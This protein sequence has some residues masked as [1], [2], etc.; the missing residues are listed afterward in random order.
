MTPDPTIR[1]Q[2][3]QYFLQEAPELLQALEEGLLSLRENWGINQVN[4]LMR[5]THTLKG[6]AT[7]MG[8]DTIAR[9]AHSLEDIFKAL[10]QPDLS[11]DPEVEALL[12]E[13]L[14]CLRLPLMAELTQGSINDAEVLN[15]T[16]AVFA[17]LQDKLGDCFGREPYLPTSSELGFDLPQSLFEVGVTQ[18]LEQIATSLTA[19]DPESVA[20]VL[21]TQAEVLLGLA[22]SL[23]LCGFGAIAQSAIAALDCHP[24]QAVLIA[25]TALADFQAGQAA[26]LAGDRAQGGEPSI[27]LQQFAVPV[28]SE[29]A[30]PIEDFS[31]LTARKYLGKF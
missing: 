8:L 15:R 10:C 5:A 12:F 1:A 30:L 2:T 16:A 14:E 29:A 27:G 4:N 25:Q 21:R 23:N 24:E 3:Y 7:S 28:L 22:E 11:L 31:K 18:R 19:A 6:A 13:A 9:I 17:L 26:V 20:I